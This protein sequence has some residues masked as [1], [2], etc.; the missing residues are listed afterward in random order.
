VIR[1]MKAGLKRTFIAGVFCL[2][3]AAAM[4]AQK[5]DGAQL[6]DAP[7][8]AHGLS[9]VPAEAPKGVVFHKKLFWSLVTADAGS[10]IADAQTSRHNEDLYPNSYEQNSW[11]YG[12]RPSLAR[13]Y[14][15]DL[16]VDG[17]SAL[18]SYELL[19]SHRRGLRTTGWSL[20]GAVL[21]AH[22]EGWIYNVNQLSKAAPP[23]KTQH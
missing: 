19:H 16:A 17:G 9:T 7:A 10:A 21:V 1:L 15:T 11:L 20:L 6:P 12:K 8:A 2:G 22:T 14:V 18:I 4:Q 23:T 3:I 5:R 13:Y